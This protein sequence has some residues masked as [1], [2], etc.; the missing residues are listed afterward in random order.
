MA[1]DRAIVATGTA[2]GQ[3]RLAP[4]ELVDQRCH[5]LVVGASLGGGSVKPA[6]QDGHGRMIG[7]GSRRVRA[8]AD[9]TGVHVVT[10]PEPE[11]R[12]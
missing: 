6:A 9:V 1:L 12:P 2:I 10:I 3:L 4:T 5:R 11:T 8:R 7:P